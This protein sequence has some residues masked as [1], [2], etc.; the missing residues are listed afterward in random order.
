MK[1]A[2]IRKNVAASRPYVPGK[3]IS[4]LEREYGCGDICKLASNEN[5]LGPSPLVIDALHAVMDTVRLYPDG[6]CFYLREKLSHRMALSP[7]A[8]VFGNGS[9]DVIELV[10]KTFLDP[11]DAVV[12]SE[13]AFV[14]YGMVTQ[15]MNA[16]PITV[17]MRHLTHDLEAMADAIT[18]NTKIVV[19]CNP[20]NPTGTVFDKAAFATFMAR[21][22]E[23]IVVVVDEA[24]VEYAQRDPFPDTL[25]YLRDGYNI[26]ILRTFSKIYG[27]AGLRIGYGMTRPYIAGAMQKIRQPFNVNALAQHAACAA[28]DDSG[29]VARSLAVCQEGMAYLQREVKRLCLSF[30]PSSTNFLLVDVGADA[31]VCYNAL[32]EKGVIVRPMQGYDLPTFIRVTVGLPDENQRF[33]TA[34]DAFLAGRTERV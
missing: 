12:L 34:M 18:E 19:L 24:Y 32:L 31:R 6:T 16:V 4:A 20:N 28:L 7:E 13:K 11:G 1:K 10:G 25:S 9:N 17:P 33:I 30:V 26:V 3:P 15:L 21:L 22:P 23:H 14:V 2:P 8:F 29:H 5:P 27:L